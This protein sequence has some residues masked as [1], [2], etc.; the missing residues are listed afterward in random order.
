M[1]K[2]A[3]NFNKTLKE[4]KELDEVIKNKMMGLTLLSLPAAEEIKE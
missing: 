1:I 2:R 3:I 4:G